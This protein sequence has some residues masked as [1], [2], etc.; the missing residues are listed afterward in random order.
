MER[1]RLRPQPGF[2]LKAKPVDQPL[3]I[4]RAILAHVATVGLPGLIDVF[5]S[6]VRS[7]WLR[8]DAWP[9]PEPALMCRCAGNPQSRDCRQTIQRFL[10][11][12]GLILLQGRIL[13]GVL[14]HL[15]RGGSQ[16]VCV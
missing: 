2:A 10:E 8:I 16:E 1:M 7:S 6:G 13:T 4:E 12:R 5:R 3:R 9:I 15:F 11:R 14:D